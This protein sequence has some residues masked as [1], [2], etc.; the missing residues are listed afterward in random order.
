MGNEF[1]NVRSVLIEAPPS[2]NIS[3]KL[4]KCPCVAKQ[5]ATLLCC[6]TGSLPW[7]RELLNVLN[8]RGIDEL[9]VCT[10][11]FGCDLPIYAIT[12]VMIAPLVGI[13]S[14]SLCGAWL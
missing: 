7:S 14:V 10:T 9:V 11:V 13:L 12:V 1:D 6:V 2:S 5:L 8:V 4:L 3:T